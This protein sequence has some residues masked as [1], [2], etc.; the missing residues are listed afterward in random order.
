MELFRTTLKGHAN[1]GF[2]T[3]RSDCAFKFC[4]NVRGR[5]KNITSI[6]NRCPLATSADAFYYRNRKTLGTKCVLTTKPEMTEDDVESQ[7]RPGE[8]S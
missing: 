2:S 4:E 5:V 8:S 1:I 7:K 3:K 6:L